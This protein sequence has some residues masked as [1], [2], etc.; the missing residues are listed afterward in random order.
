MALKSATPLSVSQGSG[1]PHFGQ[2]GTP[3]AAGLTRVFCPQLGQVTTLGSL[4][5]H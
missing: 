3:S 5:L 2:W 1:R 4:I